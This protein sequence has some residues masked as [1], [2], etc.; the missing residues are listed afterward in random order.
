MLAAD[1]LLTGLVVAE[2]VTRFAGIKPGRAVAG[3]YYMYKTLTRLDLDTL[4]GR[5]WRTPP[6]PA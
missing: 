1:Q 6:R 3:M 4:L 2:A 5:C